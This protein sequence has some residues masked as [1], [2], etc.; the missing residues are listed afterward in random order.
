MWINVGYFLIFTF[1][2]SALCVTFDTA[3]QVTRLQNHSEQTWQQSEVVVVK[4]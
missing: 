2:S 3:I 1:D 4:W